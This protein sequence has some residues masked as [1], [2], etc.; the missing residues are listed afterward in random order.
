MVLT[1]T[2]CA[3]DAPSEEIKK[4]KSLAISLKLSPTRHGKN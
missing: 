3:I 2:N 1:W 4:L